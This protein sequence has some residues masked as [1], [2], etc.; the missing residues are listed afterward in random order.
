[1]AVVA[2]VAAFMTTAN[3]RC[4]QGMAAVAAGLE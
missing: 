4:R 2:A 1:M 3:E